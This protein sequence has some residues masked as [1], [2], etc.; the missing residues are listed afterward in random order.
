MHSGP[1]RL[2]KHK[3]WGPFLYP[4]RAVAMFLA[5]L[6]EAFIETFPQTRE[7]LSQ[8]KEETVAKWQAPLKSPY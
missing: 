2:Y 3:S 5:E 6:H 1:V 8:A 7:L 4:T